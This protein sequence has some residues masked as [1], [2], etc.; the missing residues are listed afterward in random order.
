MP[1]KDLKVWIESLLCFKEATKEK[2][3]PCIPILQIILGA[4]PKMV[5]NKYKV[6]FTKCDCSG[7]KGRIQGQAA[8]QPVSLAK[9][10]A[11]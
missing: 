7:A 2:L 5:L 6:S 11:S 4:L 10:Y 9:S 3:M 8:G 1:K